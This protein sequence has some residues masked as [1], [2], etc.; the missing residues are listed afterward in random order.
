MKWLA[1]G[2]QETPEAPQ[3]NI[4]QSIFLSLTTYR[5][6]EQR[7]AEY[8]V[9]FCGWR[10]E[11]M[12]NARLYAVACNTWTT[13]EARGTKRVSREEGKREPVEGNLSD[14]T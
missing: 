5:G 12:L 6:H 10:G 2:D 8:E 4:S 9:W 13:K 14:L 11:V 7:T 3:L 1:E